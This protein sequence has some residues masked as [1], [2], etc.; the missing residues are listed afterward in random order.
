V[1]RHLEEFLDALVRG[2]RPRARHGLDGDDIRVAAAAAALRAARPDATTPTP[3]FVDHL[4][5]RLR[6]EVVAQARGRQATDRRR[7]LA[8]AASVAGAAA[9]GGAGSD[10]LLTAEQ[11]GTAAPA[12][13]VPDAGR[14]QP[15]A[16]LDSVRTQ[17]VV[18]FDQAGVNGFVV[19]SEA[20]VVAM[21]AV[22][23]HLGCTL[24]FDSADRRLHCPCHT[25]TAFSLDGSLATSWYP[26]PALPRLQARINGPDVEV[27]LP[28][29]A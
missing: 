14:W 15:V 27:L 17:E 8:V 20:G 18:R 7:F 2:R 16:T 19:M 11:N 12:T 26:L 28:T 25:S 9:I 6:A 10:R 3:E 24:V 29:I 22:C 1:N 13:L 4:A 21:S 23:T 5:G